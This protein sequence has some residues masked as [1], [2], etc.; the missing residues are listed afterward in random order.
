MTEPLALQDLILLMKGDRTYRALEAD[1]GGIVKS[2]RWNQ[3]ANGQRINEFPEPRTI[4]AMADALGVD[5]E[6]V[7]VAFARNLGLDVGRRR[8]RFSDLLPPMVDKLSD[9]QQGAVLSVIRAMISPE[10]NNGGIRTLDV[11][12][13]GPDVVVGDRPAAKKAPAR[14]KAP[15]KKKS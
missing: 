13:D 14:K 6:V 11:I 2:Q 10:E 5:A 3:L 4:A 7:L 12:S 15:A 8:S 1:T 9:R